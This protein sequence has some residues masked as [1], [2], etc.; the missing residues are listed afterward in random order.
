MRRVQ[1]RSR[2]LWG[3]TANR[4]ILAEA[5]YGQNIRKLS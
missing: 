1:S 3:P 5:G 4:K 2:R